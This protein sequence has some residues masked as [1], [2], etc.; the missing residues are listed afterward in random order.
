MD[1]LK[2]FMVVFWAYTASFGLS[3][4]QATY[5]VKNS[6]HQ[7]GLLMNRQPIENVLKNP[8]VPDET[9]KKLK[10]AQ[11][12]IQFA[13]NDLKLDSNGN[14]KTYVQLQKPYVTWIVRASPVYKLEHYLWSFPIVGSVPYKGFFSEEEAAEEARNF[15]SEQWDTSVRGVTAYST[16]GWFRDPLLSSMVRY[17][18]RDLVNV[19]IHETVHANLY[20]KGEADFNER[21]ATFLGNL[22]T[23]LY[24]IKKEGPDSPTVQLIKKE[25]ADDKLFSEW[26]SKEIESLKKWYKDYDGKIAPEQKQ[27]RLNEIKT[28]FEKNL[29]PRLQ[30]KSFE[31]FSKQDLNNAS[32]LNYQ[33][34]YYDLSDFEKLSGKIGR[35][36]PALLQYCKNLEKVKSPESELKS[37]ISK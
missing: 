4:C 34:Y 37:F 29:K 32:L 9:K 18:D 35:D 23:E 24:Y 30:S 20:I 8:Q 14:Y 7:I 17:E 12:A 33:T 15:P 3:G 2:R 6:Y 1:V 21:L 16:L 36:F 22:G 28:S 19:I 31:G 27:A 26:I 11:D 25:N 10:V 5:L 13:E